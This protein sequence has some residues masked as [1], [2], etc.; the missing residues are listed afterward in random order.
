MAV[1]QLFDRRTLPFRTDFPIAGI[2]CELTTNSHSVLDQAARWKHRSERG[3]RRTFQMEII[4]D[5][6]LP[7]FGDGGSHFRG[8][9][10]IVV[11]MMGGCAHFVFD[12]LRRRVMGLVPPDVAQDR[13]FWDRRLLPI[14]VGVLGAMLEV[15]PLHSACLE[16]NGSGVMIAGVSGAGKS[17]LSAVLAQR[18]FGFVSDD[19]TYVANSTTGLSAH[20]LSAPVKLLP[21]SVRFIDELRRCTAKKTM[22]GEIAYEIDPCDTLA[23]NRVQECQPRWLFILERTEKSGCSFVPCRKEF[24]QRFFEESAE[25]MPD[26]L[27]AATA[28]RSALIDAVAE[29]PCWIIRSGESPHGT[30]ESLEKFLKVLSHDAA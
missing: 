18:G 26:E 19:W 6:S 3:S 27:P 25:R 14:T 28:A 12:L 15:A 9:R 20:G 7:S 11:A 30:A 13:E 17:T 8:Q 4:E 2:R 16:W 10:H 29:R 5:D 23:A 22:N 24:V 21:D 1:K